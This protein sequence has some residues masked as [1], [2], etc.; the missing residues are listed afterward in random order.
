M[1][2]RI[3][4]ETT[5]GDPIVVVHDA[6]HESEVDC[7]EIGVVQACAN[8]GY[9]FVSCPR[10]SRKKLITADVSKAG[11]RAVYLNESFSN[12]QLLVQASK[13]I[14]QWETLVR[15]SYRLKGGESVSITI[16]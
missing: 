15:Q 13:L 9:L 7:E 11:V 8:H 1:A 2:I 14:A 10:A 5:G 4:V 16:R 6:V 3:L 12:F